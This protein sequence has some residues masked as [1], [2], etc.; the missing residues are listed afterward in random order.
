M[1]NIDIKEAL[2]FHNGVLIYG[3]FTGI[4]KVGD[5]LSNEYDNREVYYVVELPL[6]RRQPYLSNW[7]DIIIKPKEN[8]GSLLKGDDIAKSLIGKRLM[9]GL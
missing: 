4:I 8:K 1:F 3:E 5:I 6:I 9:V 2:P 7:I